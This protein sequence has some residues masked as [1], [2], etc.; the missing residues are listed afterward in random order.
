MRFIIKSN[1]EVI[2]AILFVAEHGAIYLQMHP[3]L[4]GHAKA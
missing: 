1:E 3:F 2:Q 4:W